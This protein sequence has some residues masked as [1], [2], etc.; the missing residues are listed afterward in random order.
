M[1][2]DVALILCFLGSA[3]VSYLLGSIN[4]AIIVT[5]I[6]AHRDIRDYGSGNAGMTNVLRTLGK[7]PA[8]L[9][10][11]GDALKGIV[12][13][14]ISKALFVYFCYA[15]ETIMIG[16]VAGLFVLLGHIFPLYYHFK[17][18]KGIATSAGVMLVIDPMTF[19]C[20]LTAF[21]VGTWVSKYVSVGS[22]AASIAYPVFTC[23]IHIWRGDPYVLQRTICAVILGCIVILMH[24]GNIKRLMNGT[25]KSIKSKGKS[26]VKK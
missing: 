23:I 14:F 10:L 12:A 7:G 3:V 13:V 22:I 24:R 5:R 19:L 21:G 17:G 18:G 26:R 2:E 4:F 1:G 15:D 25:E 11:I 8:A 20:S 9:T 6:F 16:Y